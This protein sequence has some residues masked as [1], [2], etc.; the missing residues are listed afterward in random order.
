MSD[1]KQVTF[2]IPTWNSLKTLKSAWKSI[3][4]QKLAHVFVVDNNSFDGSKEW[5]E[6]NRIKVIYQTKKGLAN[7]RNLAIRKC[8][9][10]LLASIDADCVLDKYWLKYA[11]VHL[12]NPKV[13]GLCGRLIEK[14]TATLP[15][16]WREFH[17]GQHWGNNNINPPFLF[18]SN[19]IFRK[20]ALLTVKGYNE[21]FGSNFEDVDISRKL[22]NAGYTLVYEPRCICYH[23]KNDSIRSILDT[24]RR[25]TYYSY[26]LPNSFLGLLLRITMYNPHLFLKWI[27][28][29][30]SS[31][32]FDL[33]FITFLSFFY[34]EYYDI[35]DYIRP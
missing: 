21:K 5:F 16:R 15:D 4:R 7:A 22:K 29:D 23:M 31:F 28:K 14:N 10:E 30:V 6:K 20:Q 27:I 1:K 2:Y 8:Q 12:D 18:G 34:N 26:P 24:Q 32:R 9:S 33:A 35:R 13:A 3:I 19:S 11:L 25:W 17:L